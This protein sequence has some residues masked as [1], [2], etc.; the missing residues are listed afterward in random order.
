[1]SILK[2]EID[3]Q[4]TKPR[5]LRTTKNLYSHMV[6]GRELFFSYQNLVAID[7]LISVNDWSNT[8]ARHLNWINPNKEIRVEDFEEQARKLL[9]DDDL[10]SCSD[11]LRSSDPLK[12]VSNISRIIALIF[13]DK[14][15][16]SIRKNNNQRKRFYET[17]NGISFPSD[18]DCLDTATQK[19]RL[20]ICDYFNT[21]KAKEY[22]ERML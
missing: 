16:E 9:K 22:I 20:D 6:N 5:Y 2:N 19:R 17:V 1:M 14:S 3:L 15:E 4:G 7:D 18:W 11:L 10:I 21:D 8:T 13:E 12:T